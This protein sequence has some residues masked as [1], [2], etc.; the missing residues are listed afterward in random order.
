MYTY[1]QIQEEGI[2]KSTWQGII[3][4]DV[5]TTIRNVGSMVSIGMPDTDR[6]I[7]NIMSAS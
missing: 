3:A 7:I 1:V 5:E 4:H 6:A 2:H